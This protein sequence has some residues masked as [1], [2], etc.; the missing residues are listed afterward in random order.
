[1]TESAD[2]PYDYSR[3][4]LRKSPDDPNRYRREA[5][6]GEVFEDVMNRFNHGSET[7]F[8]ALQVT[9]HN[10]ISLEK[11]TSQAR[12]AWAA[13]RFETPTLAANIAYDAAGTTLLTYRQAASNQEATSWAQR[14]VRLSIEHQNL[15]QLRYDLGAKH[16]PDE[17]DDVPPGHVSSCS[18]LIHSCHTTLDGAG[19]KTLAN[20]FL[21]L[22]A[23]HLTDEGRRPLLKWGTKAENLLPCVSEALGP[24]EHREGA[25]YRMHG[26]KLRNVGI[27]PTRRLGHTFSVSET[28]QIIAASR[29]RGFTMNQIAHAAL[30]LVAACDNPPQ[31]STPADAAIVYY[32]L[33]DAR[34]RL[35]APYNTRD[36]YPGFCLATSPIQVPLRLCPSSPPSSL[37]TKEIQSYL[38]KVASVLKD[39]YLKQKAYPSL[40][41]INRE[42][43]E[44]MLASLQ[45]RRH[46]ETYLDHV[47]KNGVGE[48]VLELNDFFISLNKTDP[49]PFFRA[50]T[51]KGKPRLSVDANE[52]A[53]PR[54][55][56]Q[57][58]QTQQ[59]DETED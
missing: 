30:T 7:L 9:L 58:P 2:P 48:V 34:M 25:G 11:F 5:S 4:Q 39:E 23:V 17:N 3:F 13:L 19:L 47:H 43:A 55:V 15:D 52:V 59:R 22:L 36:G 12:H 44:M 41:A 21:V 45:D 42:Q 37:S 35:A 38:I 27:G 31:E 16:I 40:L 1:M 24:N 10:A 46:R 20:K 14:T 26:F 49:G 32:G 53:M 6:G 50:T 29:E 18:L 28:D 51:W 33:V 57:A 8:F 56:V 54:G